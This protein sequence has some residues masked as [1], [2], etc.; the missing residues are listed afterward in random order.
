MNYDEVGAIVLTIPFGQPE[1]LNI[2]CMIEALNHIGQLFV[3]F[4]NLLW[5]GRPTNRSRCDHQCLSNPEHDRLVPL[6]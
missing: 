4:F 2:H 5:V 1:R 6:T 3:H